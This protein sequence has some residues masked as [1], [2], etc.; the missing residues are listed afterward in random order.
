[1]E[2]IILNA[3]PRSIVGK[4]VKALR[5]QGKVPATLYG[6]TTTP[7]NLQVDTREV[8]RLLSHIVGEAQLISLRL[9]GDEPVPVL[10]REVQRHPIRG[11]IMHIDLYAVPMDRPI[12]TEVLVHLVGHSPLVEQ[13]GAMLLH[14]LTHVE[15][16]CLPRDLVAA[17]EV[18][19]SRLATLDDAIHVRDLAAPPGVS[20]LTNP[21]ELVVRLSPVAAEE[22]EEVAPAA[23]AEEVEVIGKGKAAEEEEAEGEE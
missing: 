1:M 19:I 14:A 8:S 18:D 17:I 21:E 20:I 9:E 7:M 3:S 2:E 6:P 12:S 22:V 11:D 5:R 13:R 16:E 15:I 23:A 10:A 4:Q